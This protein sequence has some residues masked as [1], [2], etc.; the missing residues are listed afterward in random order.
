MNIE[1][2][3]QIE[4]IVP[5]TNDEFEF[6]LSHFKEKNFK[7]HQ[8]I[9]HEGDYVQYDFYVVKGLMKSSHTNPE[10]KEHMIQFALENWWITDPQAFHNSTKAT[11]NVDCLEDTKVLAISLENREKLCKELQK[12][13]YF[14][15]K[16][17]TAG[18]IAL[19]KRILCLISSTATERYYNLL[20]QYPGLI[21]RIPKQMVASYLGVSRE[22]LSRLATV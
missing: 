2:R 16:K 7:K 14:F 9:I 19:Q 15:L 8:I 17:T 10:G 4:K 6:V 5:L 22:T 1:L 3:Q 18:Y 21:Q 20:A 12:M 13:E 11:L